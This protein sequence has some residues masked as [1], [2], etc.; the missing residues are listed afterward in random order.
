[1]SETIH[2]FEQAGLGK[3]P[4]RYVGMEYQEISYGQ[5]VVGHAGG[6]PITTKPG[7]LCAYCGQY[8]VNMFGVES[9]DGN[10]FHVGC[11]C[12]RKTGDAGM[13][14][15]VAADE[16]KRKNAQREAAEK[17]RKENDRHTCLYDL[18]TVAHLLA[19]NPH[20]NNYRA[21]E[22]DTEFDYVRW[23]IHHKIYGT[24]AKIIRSYQKKAAE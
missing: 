12:I 16:K 11:E 22:G 2:A 5:A 8:I 20:P 3:A 24:A 21:N 4:F 9:A 15:L 10:R 23:M 18:E 1:M 14:K 17:R 6:V 19:A 13:M 7:G